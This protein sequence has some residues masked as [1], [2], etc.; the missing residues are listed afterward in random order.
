[1]ERAG[2]ELLLIVLNG[3]PF[4]RPVLEILLL[5]ARWL[6]CTLFLFLL[7]YESKEKSMAFYVDNFEEGGCCPDPG[8]NRS[9]EE[10]WKRP[11]A[12]ELEEF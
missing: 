11:G 1:M 8:R 3:Q 12:S 5:G 6:F 10:T 4:V 9:H 7:Y 2:A